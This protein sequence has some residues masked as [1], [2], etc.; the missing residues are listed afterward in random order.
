MK[1]D[2]LR[3]LRKENFTWLLRPLSIPTFSHLAYNDD[4]RTFFFVLNS[5][6][7]HP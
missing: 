4:L 5:L 7:G 2:A 1:N 3:L 6:S